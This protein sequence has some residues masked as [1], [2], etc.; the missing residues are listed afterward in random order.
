MIKRVC[1]SLIKKAAHLTAPTPFYLIRSSLAANKGEIDAHNEDIIP[2][3]RK[4]RILAR[5][6]FS[7]DIPNNH[8]YTLPTSRRR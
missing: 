5:Y 3:G 2:N 7:C 1:I 4:F 8:W 6:P